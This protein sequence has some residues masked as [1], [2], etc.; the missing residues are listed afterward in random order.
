MIANAWYYM[1]GFVAVDDAV[2]ALGQG[3]LL[4]LS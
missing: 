3:M 2:F 1:V 4:W